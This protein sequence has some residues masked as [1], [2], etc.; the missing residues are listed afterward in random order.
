MLPFHSSAIGCVN[1]R[2]HEAG[3]DCHRMTW[4]PNPEAERCRKCGG[5]GWSVLLGDP[6]GM[7]GGT[8]ERDEFAE[9]SVASSYPS[10]SK[11][12]EPK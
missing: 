4:R 10:L 7:C 2:G 11:Q 5:T 12:E 1:V 9:Q 8:K 6:C 3:E